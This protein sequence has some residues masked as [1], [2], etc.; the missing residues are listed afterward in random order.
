M[1]LDK[2][3]NVNDERT[4]IY[5]Y[6]SGVRYAVVDVTRI[7]MDKMGDHLIECADGT[8]KKVKSGY[9]AIEYDA[10]AWSEL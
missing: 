6:P 1:E 5:V 4:R 8:K 9:I 10:D 2:W 7:S 3:Y